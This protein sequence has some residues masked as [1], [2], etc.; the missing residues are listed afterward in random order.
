M[1]TLSRLAMQ[2]TAIISRII[3]PEMAVAYGGNREEDFRHLFN[4]SCQAALWFSVIFCL[5]LAVSGEL[6]LGVW[7]HGKVTMHWPLYLLLLLAVAVN[8]V[9]YVA[10]MAAYATNRHVKVAMVYSMV[11]GGLTF[12][13]AV[14][15][16]KQLGVAGAG[17]AIF[18]SEAVMALVALPKM[19]KLAGE[20][21]PS[22][23]TG[24]V[25]P[26][27]FLIRM[28]RDIGKV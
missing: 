11:Y 15:L 23:V 21:F 5:L 20:S 19:L 12:F 16:L 28:N 2:P 27:L 8:A 14:F 3:E 4:R 6:L 13:L 17:L 25:K 1:R 22:W 24:I 10:L 26:P 7:T 18:L 9:W